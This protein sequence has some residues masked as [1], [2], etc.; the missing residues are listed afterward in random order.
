ML[1]LAALVVPAPPTATARSEDSWQAIVGAV[2]RSPERRA[3]TVAAALTGV[4]VSIMLVYQVPVMAAAGLP[5]TT[6]ATIAGLRGIAQLGGRIPL[7]YLLARIP[8][9]R[10]LAVAMGAIAAGALL[11]AVASTIAVAVAFAVVAGFGI[12]AWSPLQGVYAESLFERR[13]LGTTLGLYAAIGMTFGAI[14]PL[15]AGPLTDATADPRLAAVIAAAT[16][17]LG[18]LLLAHPGRRDAG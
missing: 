11:L 3:L 9:R 2:V 18:A 5:L 13:T 14:G 12:G 4:A 16:A 8:T 10:L 1:A 17:A 15:I 6:A 7:G